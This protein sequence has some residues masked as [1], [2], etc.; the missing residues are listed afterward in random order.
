VTSDQT[1]SVS[2]PEVPGILAASDVL[3]TAHSIAEVQTGDGIIPWFPGG[4]CDPWNHVEAAMALL[5]AGRRERA[6]AA[7]RWSARHQLADGSW[8]TYYLA[9]G[10]E[11][12]RRDPNVCAYVA[13]GAWFHHLVTGDDALLEEL[14]PVIDAAIGFVLG[15]T[16]NSLT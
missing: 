7:L 12:P 9:D 4:H 1:A 6:E 8:C 2:I 16:I 13:T 14:W 15:L 3:A 5:V 10:V 11:D